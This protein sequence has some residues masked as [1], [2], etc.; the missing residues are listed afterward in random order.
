MDVLKN[1]DCHLSAFQQ[2]IKEVITKTAQVR[3]LKIMK[4]KNYITILL[5]LIS[6]S[7]KAQFSISYA[8]GYGT[9]QMNDLKSLIETAYEQMAPTLPPGARIVDNFPGYLTHTLDGTYLLKHH[10]MGLKASYLTT[11]ATI[12][13]SDYSGKYEEKIILNGYRVG[14]LYRIHSNAR[15]VGPYKLSFFGEF[16]PA[17]TLTRLKYQASINLPESDVHEEASDNLSTD[18]SGYSLQ[19]LLGCR[20]AVARQL[21]FFISA[22]YDFEFGAK[23][24]TTNDYYR[25]DWSGFRANAGLSWLFR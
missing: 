2:T 17:V 21:A 23:L 24:S 19:P 10:E 18:E 13:Y 4:M 9:Y 8:A 7:A 14:L 16:S 5:I 25:A 1:N 11:G 20:L 6:F 12:A 15:K 22:G 3:D